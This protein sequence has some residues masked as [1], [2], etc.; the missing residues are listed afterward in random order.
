MQ[1]LVF[2]IAFAQV[3][4]VLILGLLQLSVPLCFWWV[5]ERG[6]DTVQG[7]LRA[8]VRWVGWFRTR[9]SPAC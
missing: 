1:R 9:T 7:W 5:I 3:L 6:W 8:T 2:G 4:A